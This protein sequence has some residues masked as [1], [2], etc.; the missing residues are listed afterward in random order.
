MTA[1]LE[2]SILDFQHRHRI[3]TTTTPE[4]YLCEETF[5]RSTTALAIWRPN[6]TAQVQEIVRFAADHRIAIVPQGG[7]SNRT[8]AALPEDDLPSI[9]VSMDNMAAIEHVAKSLDSITVQAGCTLAQVQRA[10]HEVNRTFGIDL[11]AR[12]WCQIGGN[13]STNAGGMQCL[14][15]GNMREQVLGLEVVTPNGEKLDMLNSL[16]KNNAGYD[17]KQLFIGAEG[18]LGIITRA[19]L[20]LHSLPQYK[21]TAALACERLEDAE[22]V[23]ILARDHWGERLQRLEYLGRESQRAVTRTTGCPALPFAELPLALLLV[24]ISELPDTAPFIDWL[25]TLYKRGF[26]RDVLPAESPKLER[27][28]WDLRERCANL[29]KVTGF[30]VKHDLALPQEQL[31][32]FLHAADSA[33]QQHFPEALALPL[34]HWGDGNLHF[35]VNLPEGDNPEILREKSLAINHMIEDLAVSLGGTF[36][37]EHGI[38]LTKKPAL[39]RLKDPATLALMRQIKNTLDPHGIMNPNKIL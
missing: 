13:I 10:A 33:L 5:H 36:S 30:Q 7:H 23:L 17:L 26:V 38:G 24:E 29:Q 18:T 6:T 2:K 4:K 20:R 21:R 31:V 39:K 28:L 15:F 27:E 11:G 35:N 32:A 37:A 8:L 3:S 12:E 19:T 34:G 25:G 22:T 16:K 9:V 14:R 1:D